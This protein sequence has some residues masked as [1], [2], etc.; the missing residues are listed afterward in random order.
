MELAGDKR[1]LGVLVTIPCSPWS[2]ARF[3][4]TGEKHM[5]EPLFNQAHVDGIPDDNGQLPLQVVQALGMVDN[6]IRIMEPAIAHNAHVI[7]EHPV[8]RG[9]QSQFAIPGREQHSTLFDSGA[10]PPS[11]PRNHIVNI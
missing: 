5:P 10:K 1:C 3:N 2:A 4:D 6:V 7:A 11:P 8:G 9:E